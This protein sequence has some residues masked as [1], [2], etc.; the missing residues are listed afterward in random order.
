[1]MII[2]QWHSLLKSQFSSTLSRT[3]FLAFSAA[4]RVLTRS[5]LQKKMP[6]WPL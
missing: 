2:I 1:M 4:S 6:L 3:I 5:H